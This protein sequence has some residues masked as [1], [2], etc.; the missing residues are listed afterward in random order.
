MFGILEKRVLSE[1]SVIMFRIN[2]P[3]IAKKIKPG[4][5]V[6]LRA[7]ETGERIPLT[8][9][10]AHPDQG[11]LRVY[12][13]VVGKTTALLA[14]MN[15]GEEILDV[16]GPL[17]EPSHLE[18]F[19][20][21]IC[22]GG[23]MGIAVIYPVTKALKTLGNHV[24][25]IIGARNKDLLI[26]ED[27]MREICDEFIITTDDGSYG[28]KGFVTSPLKR[29]LDGRKDISYIMAIGPVPMMK[30]VSEATRPYGIKTMVSL[31]SIMIDGTGMCGGCRVQIGNKSKFCCAHGPDFD[32]HEVDF[33]EMAMRLSMYREQEKKSYEHF[34]TQAAKGGKAL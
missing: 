18:K 20:S 15:K 16:A 33:D 28:E 22:V 24:I 8:I 30:A 32:G 34:I 2:A 25:G 27:E 21:V 10:E 23:G 29:F 1:D 14:G 12:F 31:N 17:G 19:G 9:A 7:N 3:R 13:Q 26:L 4:Q 11:W 5:F 6:I